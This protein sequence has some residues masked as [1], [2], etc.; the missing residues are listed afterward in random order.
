MSEK[1]T[2]Q[3][4][5]K[6]ITLETGRIAK[7]ADGAVTV[8]LGET[9]IVTAAVGAIKAKEG[10]DFFPL[11]V[12]YRERA[13]AAGKFPGGYF[14]REGRPTEQ[15]ILTCRLIDRPSRP[16]FPKGWR[17]ETQLIATVL[18]YDKENPSDVLAMT[19]AAAALHISN[20]PWAGPYAA[21]RIGP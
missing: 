20:I 6:Q 12:D 10:Q 5:D 16:L 8:Q 11:T 9:I 21:A 15:E 17:F 1:I 19:G 4:G 14:K 18:S 13:S 2:A 3:V 7:Q